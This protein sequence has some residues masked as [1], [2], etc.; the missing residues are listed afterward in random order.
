M[1]RRDSGYRTKEFTDPEGSAVYNLVAPIGLWRKFRR[2]CQE[3]VHPDGSTG[4]S[5]RARILTL[6]SRD[7]ENPHA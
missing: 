1:K 7:V 3:F 6:I 5:V 4:I 2:H